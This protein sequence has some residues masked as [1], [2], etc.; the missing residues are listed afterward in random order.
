MTLTIHLAED[1]EA[2]LKAKARAR[3]VSAEQYAEQVLDQ[4]L[5]GATCPGEPARRHISDVIREIWDDLPEE[6]K[7]K[8]PADGATQVDH[9][10]YGLPKREP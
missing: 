6:A 3:G 1:K 9:Y 8:L 5:E 10:V 7:A 2:A 4:D